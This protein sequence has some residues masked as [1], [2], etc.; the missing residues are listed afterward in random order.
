MN[1][2]LDTLSEKALYNLGFRKS[3]KDKPLMLIP[4]KLISI[5]PDNLK[6]IDLFGYEHVWGD[7]KDD[8]DSRKGLLSY[9]IIPK[10]YKITTEYGDVVFLHKD[11]V[12]DD[13][14]IVKYKKDYPKNNEHIILGSVVTCG[15]PYVRTYST[16][17]TVSFTLINKMGNSTSIGFD[18][19][20]GILVDAQKER[21]K[22][23]RLA[24]LKFTFPNLNSI[25]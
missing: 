23:I 4:L 25:A 10:V 19:E 12:G 5:I 2:T 18:I 11:A 14:I 24:I 21:L 16:M 1:T 17:N 3:E 6:V 7:V 20:K 9:G 15:R 22:E 13:F 8:D